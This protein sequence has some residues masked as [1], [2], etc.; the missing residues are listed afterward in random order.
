MGED[1]GAASRIRHGGISAMT[2]ERLFRVMIFPADRL[3]GEIITLFLLLP[4][5]AFLQKRM[6]KC[7]RTSGVRFFRKGNG[8][9][10]FLWPGGAFLRFSL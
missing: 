3:R 5:A 7:C 6:G 9:G 1:P 4:H 2:A 10:A 8:E